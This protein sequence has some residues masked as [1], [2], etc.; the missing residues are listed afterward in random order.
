MQEI[1]N[2]LQSEEKIYKQGV[3]F[4][5]KHHK[6]KILIR[7]FRNGKSPAHAKKLEFE[8]KKLTGVPLK[9]IFAENQKQIQNVYIK[10]NIA[11]TEIPQLIKEAKKS[12]YEL[13][14]KI[15]IMHRNLY[16]LGEGNEKNI[17]K[18]RK[19]ILDERL[20]LIKLYE[21]IY[22]LKEEY[23]ITGKIPQDLPALL[24]K[25]N[26]IDVT[27]AKPEED[28]EFAHLSGVE[29][30]KKK[31]SLIVSINKTKNRLDYQ[32]NSKK[33]KL[34]PMPNSPLREELEKKLTWFKKQFNKIV[35]LINGK[36]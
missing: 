28:C 7:Y 30:M 18:K 13:F 35:E 3:E 16:E 5:E 17:V 23:F 1:I 11:V 12:V 22:L 33:E 10:D 6:N 8:L 26:T 2:W 31:Q 29:L 20:P 19:S 14:T 24:Q 15:S 9:Q 32:N 34:N 27:T 36:K 21:Q 4:F 25:M